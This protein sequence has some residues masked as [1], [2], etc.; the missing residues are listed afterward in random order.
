VGDDERATDLNCADLNGDGL[1]D[2]LLVTQDRSMKILL[3]KPDGKLALAASNGNVVKAPYE[4]GI[5]G[6]YNVIA[7]RNKFSVANVSAGSG[8]GDS[9]V[10]YFEYSPAQSTWI[11]APAEKGLTG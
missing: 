1:Q 5:N 7:R 8:C 10:L 2:Y 4:Q 6:A 11:L 3:R 9:H